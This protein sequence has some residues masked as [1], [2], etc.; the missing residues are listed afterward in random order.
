VRRAID[1]SDAPKNR[2]RAPRLVESLE[3]MA[4]CI[5]PGAFADFAAAHAGVIRR[6]K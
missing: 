6:L 5:E 1:A 3:I 2:G 4:A